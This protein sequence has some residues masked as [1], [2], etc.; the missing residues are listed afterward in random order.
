[1]HPFAVL[2]DPVR[3]R[4]VETLATGERSAGELV[5]L[6]G[7]EFGISQS[8]VSQQL[9]VLRQ[10]GFASVRAQGKRRIYA[11]DPG[12]LRT[13]SAWVAYYSAFWGSALDDLATEVEVGK[14]ERAQSSRS[15]N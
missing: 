14:A 5:E 1:M 10:Q 9:Q 13:V 2:G 12:P 4:L 15:A 7:G 3:R 11:I 8:A 6:I